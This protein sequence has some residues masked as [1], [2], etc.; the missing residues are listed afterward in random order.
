M[1]QIT[2]QHKLYLWVQPVDFRK[3]ID[4][5]AGLCRKHGN[6]PFD[7]SIYAF[8]NR[9]G[10]SVKLLVYDGTGLWLSTKRFS[11]GSLKYWPKTSG[12]HICATT[13]TIILNQGVPATMSPSWRKLPGSF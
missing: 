3:G 13:M 1:I 4:G 6:S 9:S 5:L 8:R 12:E 7:G 10:V 11:K 2:P